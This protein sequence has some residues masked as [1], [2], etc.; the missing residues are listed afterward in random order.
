LA[1]GRAFFAPR[2]ILEGRQC[3]LADIGI[4]GPVNV[5]E[6]GGD[7]LAVFPRDEIETVAQQ[8]HDAGLEHRLRK[9]AGNRI[10][11][12]FEARELLPLS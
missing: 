4:G 3:G 5:L 11:K 8:I 2:S 7:R 6:S 12:P 9:D 10:G 1:D